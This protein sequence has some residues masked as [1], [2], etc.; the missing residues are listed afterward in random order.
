MI[1][2][3]SLNGV[4]EADVLVDASEGELIFGDLPAFGLLEDVTITKQIQY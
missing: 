4:R 2:D 1:A 3:L